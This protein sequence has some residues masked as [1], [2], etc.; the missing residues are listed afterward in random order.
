MRL[1]P[2]KQAKAAAAALQPL[3]EEP[4]SAIEQLRMDSIA[5][6]SAMLA[7]LGL[8]PAPSR[9][10]DAA[11]E[12]V[13]P[14][15]PSRSGSGGVDVAV[16][17]A[18]MQPPPPHPRTMP[19][20]CANGRFK[21]AAGGVRVAARQPP[22]TI[23]DCSAGAA[24]CAPQLAAAAGQDAAACAN[25]GQPAGSVL[26]LHTPSAAAVGDAAVAQPKEMEHS[27]KKRK[28]PVVAAQGGPC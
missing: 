26:G 16:A 17:V 5:R 27:K 12:K 7:N 18:C 14:A 15:A 23:M 2:K 9:A 10:G 1:L 3:P 13:P 4:L 25:L 28:R 8:L 19:A 22:P 21:P 6:N 11:A 20:R 24:G